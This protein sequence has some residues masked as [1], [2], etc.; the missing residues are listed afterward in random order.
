MLRLPNNH[1]IPDLFGSFYIFKSIFCLLSY[2]VSFSYFTIP[3]KDS[4]RQLHEW[5]KMIEYSYMIQEI[6]HLLSR[7]FI[8]SNTAR[9]IKVFTAPWHSQ[10][11]QCISD[12]LLKQTLNQNL[13]QVDH[14]SPWWYL[15]IDHSS[16]LH[17]SH[18][19]KPPTL[20]PSTSIVEKK[21]DRDI[22]QQWDI[23][24]CTT[25][26]AGFKT[27]YKRYSYTAQRVEN[28]P[29][30]DDNHTRVIGIWH[31]AAGDTDCGP[32]YY[33]SLYHQHQNRLVRCS[34]YTWLSVS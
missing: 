5:T 13:S 28:T 17:I 30:T 22:S 4:I 11:H 9:D 34:D 15:S 1:I 32:H 16:P 10:W 19:Q 23:N 6:F 7:F 26:Y 31:N 18:R 20:V 12:E 33:R 14:R 3:T 27:I 2:T 24:V 25:P 8:G 29:H 21:I